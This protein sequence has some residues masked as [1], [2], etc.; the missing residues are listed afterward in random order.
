M[1]F[2]FISFIFI[3]ILSKDP[4]LLQMWR[5]TLKQRKS[6]VIDEVNNS[7][8][9]RFTVTSVYY[10]DT[11]FN[12][13]GQCRALDRRSIATCA[14]VKLTLTDGAVGRKPSVAMSSHHDP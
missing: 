13:N 4:K 12:A 3:V 14:S 10:F 9:T 6:D 11:I 5:E 8:L 7:P 2:H 1:S